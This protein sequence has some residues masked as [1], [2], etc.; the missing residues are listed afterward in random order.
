MSIYSV[1]SSIRGVQCNSQWSQLLAWWPGVVVTHLLVFEVYSRFIYWVANV[2][3]SE[4]SHGQTRSNKYI[5]NTTTQWVDA[6][7][8]QTI[9]HWVDATTT[10]TWQHNICEWITTTTNK[11]TNKITIH[12]CEWLA[13]TTQL[14]LYKDDKLTTATKQL[15]YINV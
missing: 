10:Q 4:S 11:Q 8:T 1:E 2:V 15:V 13:T 9:N 12:I 7:T 6:T 3:V 14:T 5:Y